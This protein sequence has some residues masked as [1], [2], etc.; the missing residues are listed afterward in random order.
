MA[1]SRGSAPQADG[2]GV[3]QDQGRLVLQNRELVDRLVTRCGARRHAAAR[4]AVLAAQVWLAGCTELPPVP[5]GPADGDATGG[6]PTYIGSAACAA[7][8]PDIAATLELHGHSQA[9]KV[10][11]GTAPSYPPEAPFAGVPSPPPTFEWSDVAFVIGGYTK[12]ANFVDVDG[13]VLTDGAAGTPL[14]YTLERP[15]S[16]TE[17]AFVPFSPGDVTASPYPYE[18]FRCHTT[19]GEPI[20]TNGGQRQGNRPGIGGTWAE[21]GVRCEACHGPGSLHPP[22]PSGG[23]IVVDST[24]ALCARCHGYPDEAEVIVAADGFIA[25]NQQFGEVQASPHAGFACIVC[26]NPHVSVT[27]DR[28]NALRNGC[29]ACHPGQNM[30]MHEGKILIQGDYV[31]FLACESCHMPFAARNASSAAA[32]FTG[33]N[34][35]R[36]GDIRTHIMYIDTVERDYKALFTADGQE[37]VRDTDGKAAVTLDFVCLRCHNGISSAFLLTL[38]GASTI[39]DSIHNPP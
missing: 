38:D 29:R 3:R 35:G 34:G 4:L 23:T 32:E 36:I 16:A 18:C 9:L 26:H 24:A 8:H 7:C 14:Q 17:A 20:E 33:G 13:F 31:E 27:F 2:R 19:G 6:E 5:G 12:A 10:T 25:G 39:G 37:V 28:A 21:E 30:A 22:D 11:Q 15:H 1:A